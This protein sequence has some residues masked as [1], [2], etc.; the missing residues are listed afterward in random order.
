MT[1]TLELSDEMLEHL[2]TLSMEKKTQP[3]ELAVMALGE[4]LA[5]S[6][7]P[8]DLDEAIDHVLDKNAEL[9]R[10]LA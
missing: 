6:R 8:S 5:K 9:Y 4:Y 1:L 10:R 2:R 3:E 7:Q